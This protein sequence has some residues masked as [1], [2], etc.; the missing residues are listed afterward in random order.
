[1]LELLSPAGS[2]EGVIAAV[3]NGTDAIYL[4]LKQWNSCLN[5][6]NFTTNEF[7]RAL[8]YCRIR[9]VKAYLALD[10]HVPDIELP[11]I[12]HQVKEASRFGVDAIIVSDLG[13]MRAVR[14]AV[15][16]VPV[17]AS[18]R[19]GIHNLE[20]VKMAAAMG[21]SRVTLSIELTR[22][23]IYHICKHSP[24]E[25]EI[26]V[27][28]ETCMSYT[29]QC[30]MSA[31]Q[32]DSS[33]AMGRCG[34]P[35][36]ENYSW[37]GHEITHPL[38]LKDT[39]L[40]R[41]L[42]D[43]ESIGVKAVRIEGRSERPEFTALVTGVFSRAAHS[44]RSPS[45]ESMNMLKT[46]FS[47]QGFSDRYYTGRKGPEAL[48][49][50]EMEEKADTKLFSL[51]RKS[52]LNGEFQRIP[53]RFVGSISR[54]EQAK[55]AAADDRGNTAVAYGLVP[56]QSFHKEKELTITDLSTQL[57]KTHGTPFICKGVKGTVES[58]LTLPP[59][60]FT[61]MRLE[62]FAE[63]LEQR[64]PVSMRVEGEFVPNGGIYVGS[65]DENE[66]IV[67]LLDPYP[68]ELTISV[69]KSDQL[70]A[71][72]ESLAPKLIYIPIAELDYES[73][74]LRNI[75]DNGIIEVAV[76]LPRIIHDDE[77]KNVAKLLD[78]AN[79]LGVKQALVSNIGH[80]QFAKGHGMSVR[81]DFGLNVYNSETLYAL[82][83]LGLKSA[84]ISFEM[85]L[86]EIRTLVKSLDLELIT[87]GR[88]PL[89]YT[90]NCIVRNCTE[91][92]TCD[93]F[94]G[95]VGKQG[96]QYPV[97]AEFG[98][99]NVLLSPKKLFMADKYKS[100]SSLGLWAQR[101][102]FTTENAIEC[103]AVTKRYKGE[104]N[105]APLSYTRGVYFK[106]IDGVM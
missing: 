80:I 52:Y 103:V 27:H 29:G 59:E 65:V 35:C 62:L 3:Q 75:V 79:S 24:I 69:T 67:P 28:G 89:M 53:V 40:V 26:Y 90:E 2:P 25:I 96:A 19:L 73:P 82:N 56:E 7:G 61:D 16:E 13:V 66:S 36:R 1:M 72:L 49:L 78:K 85:P 57:H 91:A 60:E 44:G 31:M 51:T 102:S 81:G 99:R 21:F 34:E 6:E 70:S 94:T 17:F 86:T 64:K 55:I 101:L 43:I 58:G 77:K 9:G 63:I 84:T 30:Y 42:A 92:C 83:L 104:G 88:L 46:A 87:Y 74:V 48:G 4:G 71:E 68:P 12:A 10:N 76:T 20:G 33:D 15:P 105:Y 54:G 8:E 97:I 95:I 37:A 93:S 47:R 100:F 45:Q 32:G 18:S 23:K 98:C 14:Q 11:I 5:A 22:K 50:R 39:C 106:E 38:S 41:Y